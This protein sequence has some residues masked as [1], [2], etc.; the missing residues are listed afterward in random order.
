M[1]VFHVLAEIKK[2]LRYFSNCY[3]I[4][5]SAPTIKVMYP[6]TC[7]FKFTQF[8]CWFVGYIFFFSI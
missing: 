4:S 1:R 7:F 6:G 3:F 2:I 5:L 8:S